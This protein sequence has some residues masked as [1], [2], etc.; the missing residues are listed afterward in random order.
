MKRFH[1]VGLTLLFV[2]IIFTTQMWDFHKSDVGF[3][4]LG[5]RIYKSDVGFLQVGRRIFNKSD[6]GFLQVGCGIFSKSDVGFLQVGCRIFT[7][8]MSDFTTLLSNFHISDVGLC[9]RMAPTS[10]RIYEIECKKLTKGEDKWTLSNRN[11][12]VSASQVKNFGVLR[13]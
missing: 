5:C 9:C 13:I 10:F 2:S 1:I 3:S 11:R 7:T 4:Q 6:V 12:G 8:R